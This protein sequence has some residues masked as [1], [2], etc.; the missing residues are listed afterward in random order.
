MKHQPIPRTLF[1]ALRCTNEQMQAAF[2]R[3]DKQVAALARKQAALHRVR[4]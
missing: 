3:I 1:T 2:A 4:K